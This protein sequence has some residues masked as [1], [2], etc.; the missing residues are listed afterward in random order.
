[1]KKKQEDLMRK[2]KKRL[3]DAENITNTVCFYGLWQSPLQV[4][5]CLGRMPENEQRKAL[6]S[7]LKFRSLHLFPIFYRLFC[8]HRMEAKHIKKRDHGI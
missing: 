4:D 6:E 2:E 5:E 3:K 8:S 1:M 7:Q